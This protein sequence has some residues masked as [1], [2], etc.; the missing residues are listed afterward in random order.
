METHWAAVYAVV[1]C[2]IAGA[3]NVG[4]VP[5]GLDLLRQ[6]FALSLVAAGWVASML[7][8][9][10]VFAALFIGVV[11]DRIGHLRM[12]GIGVT[13]SVAATL[14]GIYVEHSDGLLLSRFGEGVGF[15]AIVIAA[16]GLI[17]AATHS[18]DRR[19]ALGIWA[20][21]LPTGIGI[22]M[23]AAPLLLPF[24][25]WRS[26]WLLSVICLTAAGIAIYRCRNIYVRHPE[27]SPH[28]LDDIKAAVINPMPWLLGFALCGWAIQYFALIVWL[29][30]FLK[31]Q[32]E[33]GQGM[34]GILSAAVV[35]IH[36]PGNL[37]GGVL[38]KHHFR[39]GALINVAS[40]MTAVLSLAIY[41]ELLPDLL[42][43][44][45]C[46]AL[47]FSGGLISASVIS[48][49]ETLAKTGRQIGTLQG[50]FLQI[51]HLGQFI[52][53]PLVAALVARSGHWQDALWVTGSAAITC[54]F[55]GIVIYLREGGIGV[56]NAT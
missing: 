52:G 35:L 46:L 18:S 12:V 16:P 30:T 40:I 2:G 22:A 15:L 45:A 17:S 25:G 9:L 36:A 38:V 42:R 49:T 44:L 27:T 50:L 41:L 33:M 6:E 21:Y 4:K 14:G 48:S 3:I 32:H 31:E 10:S 34:A 51:A 43:F 19:F 53:P 47:S 8:T 13:I 20:T 1:A 39:R 37:L 5:I 54:L 11:C 28:S 23:L 7:S 55:L 29:P 26:L 24:G 56:L